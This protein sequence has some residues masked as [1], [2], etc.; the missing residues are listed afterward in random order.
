MTADVVAG[1]RALLVDLGGGTDAAL[2]RR[3]HATLDQL[4]VLSPI[5]EHI[6]TANPRV[7]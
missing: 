2:R 1:F 7:R 6:M 3:R 5:V 4:P